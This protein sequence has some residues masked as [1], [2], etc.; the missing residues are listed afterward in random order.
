MKLIIISRVEGKDQFTKLMLRLREALLDHGAQ[1]LLLRLQMLLLI[2]EQR[3]WSLEQCHSKNLE[4]DQQPIGAE[5]NALGAFQISMPD[6]ST[7][8]SEGTAEN[9]VKAMEQDRMPKFPTIEKIHKESTKKATEQV[10]I[11]SNNTTKKTAIDK[12][13]TFQ[14][15]YN[16]QRTTY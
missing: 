6:G 5:R 4:L 16:I 15:F 14:L 9:T 7:L 1:V 13:G 3:H 2:K 11:L 10:G 8:K 12:L